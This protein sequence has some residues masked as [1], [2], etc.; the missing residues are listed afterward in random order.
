MSPAI[1]VLIA[2]WCFG[3]WMFTLG[4]K[5]VGSQDEKKGAH[6]ITVMPAKGMNRSDYDH[7]Y[8]VFHKKTAALS[9]FMGVYC[10]LVQG[11]FPV[12]AGSLVFFGYLNLYKFRTEQKLEELGGG[13]HVKS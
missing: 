4:Q 6:V 11:V 9:L 10:I 8:Q 5:P 1:Y 2:Y 13:K 3:A 7:L 12:I